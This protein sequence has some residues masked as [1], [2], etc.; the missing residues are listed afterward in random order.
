MSKLQI[1]ELQCKYQ[2]RLIVNGLDLALHENEILCLLGSSGCGKTTTLKAIAGL[3]PVSQGTIVLN[4]KTVNDTAV[5]T[6]PEHR[7]IGMIFQD[8][9]LFPHLTI[10]ENVGFGLRHLKKRERLQKIMEMLALVRL[11]GFEKRFPHQLSGGQQQ[12]VA[13]ARALAYEPDILLLDE[14]FSNIDPQVRLSLIEEIRHIIKVQGVAA[15]FV[16]HNKEEAFAFADRLAVMQHG[17]IAQVDTPEMLYHHPASPFVAEFLGHGSY[18]DATVV[19]P[20]VFSTKFGDIQMRDTQ[21]HALG[22]SGKLFLRPDDIQL[23]PSETGEAVVE[24]RI[25][26]GS[27]FHYQVACQ[28][29]TLMAKALNGY[30]FEVG[31]HVSAEFVD[32]NLPFFQDKA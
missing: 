22:H 18:I 23:L 10:A 7:N 29:E 17:V 32:K 25:F 16:T 1:K 31:H 2:D 8:Y 30:V 26:T 9:A 28:G 11:S 4:G 6:P 20:H 5:H 21:R 27:G 3:H 19:Q 15:I 24:K 12:R 13:I 14:P